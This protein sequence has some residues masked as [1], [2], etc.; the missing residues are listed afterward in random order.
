MLRK[1]VTAKT[2]F[3]ITLFAAAVYVIYNHG[4]QM[5]DA[6]QNMIPSEES[7]RREQAAMQAQMQA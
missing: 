5:N 3:D 2:A 7:L 4:Q 6:L 1:K